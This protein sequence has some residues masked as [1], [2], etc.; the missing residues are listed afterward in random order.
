MQTQMFGIESAAYVQCSSDRNAKVDRLEEQLIK[1]RK[2]LAAVK[3]ARKELMELNR[4]FVLR[5]D[6]QN[7]RINAL[8]AMV[9]QLQQPSP[10]LGKMPLEVWRRLMQLCHPDK[11]GGS[12]AANSATQWLNQNKP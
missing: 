2:E 8:L 1:T 11:H 10:H 3:A 9:K 4:R 5:I 12:V 6:E 7:D